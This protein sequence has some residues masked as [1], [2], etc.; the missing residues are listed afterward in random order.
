MEEQYK[1]ISVKEF[2]ATYFL[3]YISQDI[4]DELKRVY[5]Y[6]WKELFT[7]SIFRLTEKSPLKRISFYYHTSYLLGTEYAVID[8]RELHRNADILQDIYNLL[9]RGLL[10]NYSPMDVITC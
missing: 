10:N 4:I 8:I 3:R 1:Q 6:D 9:S 5:P 7:L 2:G